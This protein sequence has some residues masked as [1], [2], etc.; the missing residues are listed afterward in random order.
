MLVGLVAATTAGAFNLTCTGTLKVDSAGAETI[1][2]PYTYVYRIDLDHEKWCDGECRSQRDFPNVSAKYLLLED[3]NA[4]SG[5]T[6]DVTKVWIDRGTGE[7]HAVAAEGKGKDAYLMTWSGKCEQ[8]EFS[9]FP[10]NTLT[11]ART[12]S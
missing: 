11:P 4:A 8:T 6:R 5:D 2:T 1:S 12:G 3:I 9:G 7:H 10:S